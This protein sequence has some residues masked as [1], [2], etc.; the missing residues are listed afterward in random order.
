VTGSP[1]RMGKYASYVPQRPPVG[2]FA[3]FTPW[4]LVCTALI[5]RRGRWPRV[6]C[7]FRGEVEGALEAAGLARDAWHRR[8]S[9]LSG[10]MLMRSFI[11]R[12]LAIGASIVFMDEP[13]APVDPAGRVS[14][15]RL[16]GGMA[17]E[18][19]VVVSLHD[20]MILQGMIDLIVLINK[21]IIAVGR[22]EEVLRPDVLRRVYGGLIVEVERHV[23]ISD[24]HG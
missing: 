10:G 8:L 13:F 21:R 3:P 14:L 16:I 20:Y 22:P 4:E 2:R 7:P 5:V 24:W 6:G 17:R 23:H 15:A 9:E 1:S 12:S 19:L 11:A 18:R